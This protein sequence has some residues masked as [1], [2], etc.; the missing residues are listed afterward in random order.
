[1]QSVTVYEGRGKHTFQFISDD[2]DLHDFCEMLRFAREVSLIE[3]T[4]QLYPVTE[5]EKK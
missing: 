5:E 3:L 1:M 4:I 2:L